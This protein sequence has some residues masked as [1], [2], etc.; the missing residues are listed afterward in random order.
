M[1]KLNLILLID[2][3]EADNEFH[4]IVI[5]KNE[6]T[7]ELKNITSSRLAL[8]YFRHCFEKE[9]NPQ[10][11][12]PELVFLDINMPAMNGFEVL[13]KLRQTPDPYNQ[14]EKMKLFMLTGSL[15]PDD[16]KRATEEYADLIKGFRI[17]PLT[18]TIFLEI[19]QRN[20]Y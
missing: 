1:K 19:V 17:K 14:K 12:V 8:D 9:N 18:D 13:D 7:A 4:Q 5:Q 20:F 16:Y 2:D 3:N 15:N 6:I 11:P 10:Y